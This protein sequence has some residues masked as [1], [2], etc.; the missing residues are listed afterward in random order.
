MNMQFYPRL[1]L[2]SLYNHDYSMDSLDYV[3][4]QHWH[5]GL[6]HNGPA[7]NHSWIIN[8]FMHDNIMFE[9]YISKKER[10]ENTVFL[11]EIT[12]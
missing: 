1:D 11:G 3:G 7:S 5:D 9:H 6:S 4:K 2:S 10:E 12:Y 8:T